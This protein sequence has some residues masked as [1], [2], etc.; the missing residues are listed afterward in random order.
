MLLSTYS[1]FSARLQSYSHPVHQFNSNNRL[2]LV[3]SDSLHL[4]FSYKY[5]QYNMA[6]TILVSSLRRNVL[7]LPR[8]SKQKLP[9]IR[10]FSTQT[11]PKRPSEHLT[12]KTLFTVAAIS[13]FSGGILIKYRLDTLNDVKNV[14]SMEVYEGNP[15]V[16]LDISDNDVLVG[17]I[18]I[19]LRADVVPKTAENFR[20]LCSHDNGW[21][22]RTS[23]LHAVQKGKRVFGGDFFGA[24]KSG[25]SIYGDTFPDENFSLGHIGPGTVGMRN[26]GP[27]SNNSQF[28]ITFRRMPELDGKSVVVGY[29]ISG[30]EV[31]E[32]L[33]KNSRISGGK[34]LKNHNFRISN[35]GEIKDYE[36]RVPLSSKMV[37]NVEPSA[38][39]AT[40]TKDGASVELA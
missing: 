9:L 33:D 7:A 4:Y 31:L 24:G 12:K 23:P 13:L 32:H 28:Y 39:S 16:F 30:F 19:Q 25:F 3:V 5:R 11:A 20:A 15:V 1:V 38:A 6:H 36:G 34:F 22:Y 2:N 17:R 14:T 10:K 40:T 29:V 27:D 21:G 8:I 18:V 37:P 26:W 35:C